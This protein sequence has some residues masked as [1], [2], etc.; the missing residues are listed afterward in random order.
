M[1][2]SE[3]RATVLACIA[4]D[5]SLPE[6]L[7]SRFT[8]GDCGV[9]AD[10]LHVFTGWPVV[11]VGDGGSGCVG[12][13][14]AGVRAPSGV[15]VDANGHHDAQQWLADWAPFVDAYGDGVHEYCSD[16]VSIDAAEVYG[17]WGSWP[18]PGATT[19]DPEVRVEPDP[20]P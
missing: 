1:T 15:I 6:D 7:R 11:V 17:W 16:A 8:E 10:A 5:G 2:Q 18:R 9:L 20:A 12:W 19:S 4:G 14:H 13:V 3:L